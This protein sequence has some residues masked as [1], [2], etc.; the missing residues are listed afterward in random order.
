[1]EK[2]EII[3]IGKSDNS[4]AYQTDFKPALIPQPDILS[5]EEGASFLIYKNLI[6][7]TTTTDFHKEAEYLQHVI[8]ELTGDTLEIKDKEEEGSHVIKL[9]NEY[10]HTYTN[11]SNKD[12]AYSVTI[13]PSSLTINA[14]A[15]LG[16]LN[17]IHTLKQII[18]QAKEY[19]DSQILLPH[20]SLNDIP[21]FQHRGLLLD[22]GRHFFST[23]TVQKYIDLLAYYKMNILHWH[24]TEDQGWR[25]EIDQYPLLNKISSWRT[26]KDGSR[27]GGFY[28]KKEI[29]E[30]VTFAAK[31]GITII[32]EIE[33][34][35]HAQAALAAYPQFS[36]IGSGIKV[37]NDWG[38]FKEIYCAGNDGTF[39]FLENILK[40][41]MELFPSEYIHIGGDEAPK[42][43][44]EK[45]PK[46]QK[47]IQEE[48]LHDEHELQS[49]FIQRIEKF[50]NANGRKLIGW[51][52]IL[53]G[54][55]SP[56][57]AVQS[58]R[59]MEGGITA[60]NEA[61]E[62]IMSPQSHCYFDHSL[63]EI[64]LERVYSFDPIP[65]GLELDKQKYIIGGECN[66]WTERVPNADNLDS[67]VFPRILAMSE[68][69]WS[70]PK[71]RNFKEFR[72]RVQKH[73]AY[74]KLKNVKYGD[75]TFHTIFRQV[76]KLFPRME[77]FLYE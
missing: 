13:E 20:M 47:R 40:E 30:I 77:K 33:L 51:D 43:R 41:V 10:V 25:I 54:G 73:Y 5:Y 36:C 72:S 21:K 12:E 32:P 46:C 59:G 31:R 56:N 61:H 65:A 55:L 16:I 75:E 74:L 4:K 58:W 19:N 38:I 14:G 64:N 23:Q 15:R 35:G 70:Y 52:E 48:G 71:E 18:V 69:L 66:M 50:L 57:A 24:L 11:H 34:P 67:K 1:M 53:E 60:A 8:Q 68:V 45:C 6:I 17:G 44:W 37:A 22:C 76:L 63:K 2:W 7:V 27:Y 26:E 62:A 49:Y 9:K 39:E 42:D 3:D 29:K 28:T